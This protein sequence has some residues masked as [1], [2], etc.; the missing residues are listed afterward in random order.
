M[1]FTVVV[2]ALVWAFF[3]ERRIGLDD[4]G[5]FNPIYMFVNYG[6]LTYP[7]YGYFHSMIVHPPLHYLVLGLLMKAGIPAHYAQSIPPFLLILIGV[8]ITVRSKFPEAIKIA[9]LFSL[10]AGSLIPWRALFGDYGP[11]VVRPDLHLALAWFVGLIALESG[12]LCNWNPRRLFLGSFL[13]TYASALHYPAIIAWT[14]VFIYVIWVVKAQGWRTSVKPVGSLILGVCLFGIP[15]LILYLVPNWLDIMIFLKSAEPIGGILA[16]FSKH[17]QTYNWIY[18]NLMSR[19]VLTRF[20][21]YPLALGIPTVLISVA[22]FFWVKATRGIAIASLPYTLFLLLFIQRKFGYYYIP[23]F[24]LYLS[25]LAVFAILA[26]NWVSVRIF[27]RYRKLTTPAFT[28]VLI[29][30]LLVGTPWLQ[31][32]EISPQPRLDELAIA[33]AA[34]R[35][36]LGPN[37]LVG[38]RIARSYIYGETYSYMIEPDVL[39][40]NIDGLN[41]TEFFEKFDAI[42]ED[43]FRSDATYNEFNESLSS[44]YVGRILNI[45]GFYFSSRHSDLSYLL[46]SVQRPE[47]LEGYAL[48]KTWQVLHFR[49]QTDGDYVFAAVVCDAGSLNTIRTPVSFWNSYLLPVQS[50]VR[51]QKE[52]VTFISKTEDYLSLR[53]SISSRCVI[54]D[55]IRLQA[56]LL[57]SDQLLATLTNDRPIQFHD[58]LEAAI[59]ARMDSQPT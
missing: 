30:I 22:V 13:L 57:D 25:G 6:V 27:Q 59:N 20:L 32:A 33:R 36:I 41:L 34:G 43:G 39:W 10:I 18:A 19:E 23:E 12:R 28:V 5:L 58:S 1:A 48:L 56:K 24:M 4:L 40:R 16:S 55:E 17:L 31:A 45:R 11:G 15:Y 42:G 8:L 3:I 14:G 26:M 50:N 37:A 9:L 44:W 53:P 51:P 29:L 52:L 47:S 49:E 2:S 35:Q 38:A 7:T 46:L 21:F 54:R